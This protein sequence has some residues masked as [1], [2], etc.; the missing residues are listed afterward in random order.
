MKRI[1]LELEKIIIDL[2]VNDKLST[3]QVALRTGISSTGVSKIIKRN[4]IHVRN[5]SE[6]RKG[7]ERG[8]KLPTEKIIE[9]YVVHKKT[10]D[11]IS[12]EI[13]CS[14]R[15]VLN[16][17]VKNKIK[18]RKCGWQDNYKN[19]LEDLIVDL[20]KNNK[21]LLDI[22]KEIGMSYQNTN[23][24]LKKLNLLRVEKKYK[25]M[26]G[27]HMSKEHKEKVNKTKISKKEQG[28]YD[29]IYLKRTGF[30]YQEFQKRLPEFKKYYQK[31]RYITNKQPLHTLKNFNKRGK[32]GEIGAYHL[33]HKFSIIEGFKKN[34]SPDIIGNIAN[35]HMIPWEINVMKQGDCCIE[36]EELIN[37]IN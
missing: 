3:T 8:T 5:I 19:P 36:L 15:S 21:S 22:S 24:I 20:Y 18:R 26:L 33:D 27:K 34:I 13:G 14:K 29:H 28:L 11:E 6:S 10:S 35:L 1:D 4:N 9:M 17:L 2:Y 30:T 7:V 25:G 23:R 31:V 37:S 32:A 12:K 16:I